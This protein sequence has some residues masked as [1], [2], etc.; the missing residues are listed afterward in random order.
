MCFGRQPAC[1][2]LS[3]RAQGAL[4]RTKFLILVFLTPKM[5]SVR[6]IIKTKKLPGILILPFMIQFR[7]YVFLFG[8]QKICNL[9]CPRPPKCQLKSLLGPNLAPFL[10]L[11]SYLIILL[12]SII[13]QPNF[14][15]GNKNI[16]FI[17]AFCLLGAI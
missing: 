11:H 15:S 13:F 7:S 3:R 16:I 17:S 8:R 5:A 6:V 10:V 1:L 9:P 4:K 12:V 2:G 14:A